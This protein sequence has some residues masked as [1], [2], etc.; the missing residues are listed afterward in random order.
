LQSAYRLILLKK[1][2]K[3]D[4]KKESKALQ[5]IIKNSL[6]I[7]IPVQRLGWVDISDG[8]VGLAGTITSFIGIYD[9]YPSAC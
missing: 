6:D 3:T 4:K 7:A 1:L 2:G 5:G 8:V 9:T